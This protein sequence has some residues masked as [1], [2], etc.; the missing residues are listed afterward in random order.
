M[1][2]LKKL[3]R[4]VALDALSI[5]PYV[6]GIGYFINAITA[7]FF[8]LIVSKSIFLPITF[9]SIF[10]T[11]AGQYIAL[12][13]NVGENSGLNI[14][15][16]TLSVSRRER[17]A[18]RYLFAVALNIAVA[19]LG[20][21]VYF[22]VSAFRGAGM[23][24]AA[25]FAVAVLFFAQHL[26]VQAVQMAVYFRKSYLKSNK[27]FFLSYLPV[28]G[29][30]ALGSFIRTNEGPSFFELNPGLVWCAALVIMVVFMS[31]SYWLSCR[32]YGSRD[33]S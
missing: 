29:I 24:T 10:M 30:Y 26:S 12:V 23:S 4:L 16:A 13:F 17:V 6:S 32:F 2:K 9:F 14:L 7:V 31:V 3:Y 19:A 8:S 27:Y 15:Y 11:T 28:F 21:L 25:V 22:I 18:A 20:V 1:P 5:K 33:L